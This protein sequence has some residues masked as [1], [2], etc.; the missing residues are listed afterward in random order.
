MSFV[1]LKAVHFVWS[2][3]MFKGDSGERIINAVI[4]GYKSFAI[5]FELSSLRYLY[6]IKIG[7]SSVFFCRVTS[8][9]KGSI[10]KI[11]A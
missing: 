7:I 4:D 10:V 9:R 8:N 5:L 6:R 3:K 2:D 1:S 11:M